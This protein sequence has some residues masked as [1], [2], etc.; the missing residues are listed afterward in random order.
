MRGMQADQQ[1]STH[2]RLSEFTLS[3]EGA[4][5]G[6]RNEPLGTQL[7]NLARVANVLEQ[8]RALLG[9]LPIVISSGFRSPAINSLV[10]GAATSLHMQGLAADFVCPGYGTPRQICRA[11]ADSPIPF[12]QLIFEGAWVHLGLSAQEQPRRELLTA[13]FHPGQRPTY[14]RGIL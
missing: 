12:D 11:I 9:N 5:R 1:L 4:R 10:G 7:A 3:Q 6:L 13:F 8:V 14:A 2:F